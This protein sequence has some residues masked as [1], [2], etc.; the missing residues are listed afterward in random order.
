MIAAIPETLNSGI[1]VAML[2]MVAPTTIFGIPVAAAIPTAP[3][4]NQPAPFV[5]TAAPTMNST[6]FSHSGGFW[7]I[8]STK[9]HPFR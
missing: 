2:T 4:V 7:K 3:S 9:N 1:V 5:I 6:R 8:D